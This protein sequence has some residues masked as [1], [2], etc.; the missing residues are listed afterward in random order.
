MNTDY[1]GDSANSS[2]FFQR[3]LI[4]MPAT[5]YLVNIPNFS[6]R[7]Y[8]KSIRDR[9]LGRLCWVAVRRLPKTAA[10]HV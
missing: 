6:K 10:R 2:I 5:P 3:G 7:E 9:D 1:N 8:A 4:F